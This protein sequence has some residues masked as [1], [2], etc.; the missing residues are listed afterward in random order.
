MAYLRL[1][2]AY[3]PLSELARCAENTRKAYELR[4]R[5]SESER[6]AISSFYEMVVTGN[7]EAAPPLI[8]HGRKAIPVTTSRRPICG[9]FM[10]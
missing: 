10:P 3:Q 9:P 1:G 5:A 4:G 7:L 2:Q 8:R 6:L